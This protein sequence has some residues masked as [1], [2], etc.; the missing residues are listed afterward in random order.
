MRNY[1]NENLQ[2]FSCIL[3]YTFIVSTCKQKYNNF[4]ACKISDHLKGFNYSTP[5]QKYYKFSDLIKSF[6]VYC[7]TNDVVPVAYVIGTMNIFFLNKF[8]TSTSTSFE[9]PLYKSN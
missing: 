8:Q 3:K 6:I 4:N 7:V 2:L 1:N 5:F 9:A